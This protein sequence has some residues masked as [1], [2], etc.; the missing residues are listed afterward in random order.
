MRRGEL[1]RC[2][3]CGHQMYVLDGSER[4]FRGRVFFTLFCETCLHREVDWWD[5]PRESDHGLWYMH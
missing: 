2:P 4:T 1:R 3:K 5:K